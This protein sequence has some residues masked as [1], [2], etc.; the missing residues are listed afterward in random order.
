[1]TEIDE[2]KDQAIKTLNDIQLPIFK[3]KRKKG[4]PRKVTGNVKQEYEKLKE[5]LE[6]DYYL[7]N[8]QRNT[9]IEIIYRYYKD[10]RTGIE[11]LKQGQSIINDR[12]SKILKVLLNYNFDLE[13]DE[14]KDLDL[15]VFYLS[16]FTNTKLAKYIL[17]RKYNI[18]YRT[19]NDRLK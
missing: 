15:H 4:R 16:F 5:S 11:F 19:L 8:K 3:K 14:G 1:M 7:D 10:Y 2:L 18:S 12:I 13:S 6:K 17:K 9:Q